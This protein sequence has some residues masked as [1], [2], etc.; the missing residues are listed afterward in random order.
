MPARV[1]DRMFDLK[2]PEEKR[3]YHRLY[4]RQYLIDKPEIVK[5]HWDKANE[6]HKIRMKEDDEYKEKVK[7][8]AQEYRENNI[9]KI[10]ES[11][12]DRAY[13]KYTYDADHRL[14][15][16][17]KNLERYH[18]KTP[19]EKRA[20]RERNKERYKE[21]KEEY[22]RNQKVYQDGKRN[23]TVYFNLE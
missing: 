4:R 11:S 5:R 16:Q 6:K 9:E 20:L 12:R 10:R 8:K 3:E 15:Q 1:G 2:N 14:K 13:I 7:A 19:E 23:G 21:K 17:Q 18:S 22:Q